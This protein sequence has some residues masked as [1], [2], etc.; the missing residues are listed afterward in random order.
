MRTK[1]EDDTHKIE[2]TFDT[3]YISTSLFRI[4]MWFEKKHEKADLFKDFCSKQELTKISQ[5]LLKQKIGVI[6]KSFGISTKLANDISYPLL[7]PIVEEDMSTF[8]DHINGLSQMHARKAIYAQIAFEPISRLTKFF[9]TKQ[10]IFS[11]LLHQFFSVDPIHICIIADKRCFAQTLIDITHTLH[12]KSTLYTNQNVVP[13]LDDG[14]LK[15]PGLFGMYTE[16]LIV[17]PYPEKLTDS[18]KEILLE[19][20]QTNAITLTTKQKVFKIPAQTSILAYA[21]PNTSVFV[22]KHVGLYKQQL[23]LDADFLEN[24]HIIMCVRCQ[25]EGCLAPKTYSETD[26]EFVQDFIHYAHTRQVIF[27]KK[28]DT[29]IVDWY[30]LIDNDKKQII[31]PITQKIVIGLIRISIAHARMHL[32]DEVTLED[33]KYAMDLIQDTLHMTEFD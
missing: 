4:P 10:K 14:A 3:K 18:Q 16:G 22:G 25:S 8:I 24:F 11:V 23:P 28:F 5:L 29:Y 31:P 13:E 30:K 1:K 15:S 26:L 17:L 9:D 6:Y 21:H 20:M 7:H 12:P 27:P 33:L 19:V 32:R 2:N